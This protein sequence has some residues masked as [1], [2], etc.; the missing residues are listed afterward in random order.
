MEI[1]PQ[2]S[3]KLSL[4]ELD[5]AL[6][7]ALGPLLSDLE[8]R[9]QRTLRGPVAPNA[10][11]AFRIRKYRKFRDLEC[12]AVLSYYIKDEYKGLLQ[13]DLRELKT[14]NKELKLKLEILLSSKDSML[15]YLYGTRSNRD[16]FGNF[17]PRVKYI[18]K[19]LQFQTF[20]PKRAR[21]TVRHRGY[22]DH[23]SCRPE[24]QWLPSSD[25]RLTDWQNQI[26]TEKS[27]FED[28]LLILR[29]YRP[30][31][32]VLRISSLGLRIT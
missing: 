26:E 32:L 24:S 7:E 28:Q 30:T 31:K 21:K 27:E 4:S 19:T 2:V 3:D 17:L 14:S 8:L 5:S 15:S 11:T 1:F 22:R 18:A 16:F 13:L 9:I 10:E 29:E 20:Y 6:Q 25:Y 12:L 23:G